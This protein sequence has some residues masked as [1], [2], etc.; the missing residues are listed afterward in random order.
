MN[1]PRRYQELLPPLW[2]LSLLSILLL[3][4]LAYQ[5]KEILVL[6][7]LGYSLAFVME[8]ALSFLE[9]QSIG[10]LKIGRT[11]GFF[12][13]LAL[14][15]LFF[16]V[17]VLTAIP[18]IS[19]EYIR[20][21]NGLPTYFEQAKVKFE[22]LLSQLEAFLPEKFRPKE[23]LD[24]PSQ[25]LQFISPDS[26]KKFFSA[27]FYTF[28][29]GYSV[30]LTLLN[31]LLL[32]FIV[33]YLAIDFPVLHRKALMLFPRDLRLSTLKIANEINRDVSAFISAQFI[34]CAVLFLLYLVGLWGIGLELAL[35]LAVISGFGNLI[36]YI[37]TIV[38]IILSSIMALVTFGDWSHLIQVWSLY[39]LVQFLEGTF[40]TPKIMGNNVGLSPLVVLLALVIGGQ[41]LGLLGLLLAIPLT[42]VAKVLLKELHLW[43]VSREGISE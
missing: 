23:L 31:L 6:L 39:G 11:S 30:T 33:F 20:L 9:K 24:S 16:V 43:I 8:P 17:L 28:L 40:I 3:S 21:S 18:T 12:L 7:V 41:L 2:I 32:P 42:A 4:S 27:I 13:I 19:K 36:P 10:K 26:L 29:G 38:G 35:L 14:V 37:G 15:A 1:N 22:P 25:L 5:L 34:V